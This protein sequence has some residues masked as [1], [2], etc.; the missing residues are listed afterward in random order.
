M[1]N[2]ILSSIAS[3][4]LLTAIAPTSIVALANEEGSERITSSES[5]KFILNEELKNKAD[6]YIQIVNNEF[7]LVDK[8]RD[9]LSDNEIDIVEHFLFEHNQMVSEAMIHNEAPLVQQGNEFIQTAE[10]TSP[11]GMSTMNLSSGG[12]S[13]N[14]TWWGLQIQ[15]SHNAVKELHSYLELGGLI[16]GAA[17]GTIKS[18]LAKKGL[19]IA[20]KWLG[21]VSLAGGVILWGMNKIDNGNGVNLNCI[22]YVPATITAR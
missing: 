21:P 22:L 15:F 9:I 12:V 18:F 4:T 14:Y 13:L 10:D 5:N 7:V 19:T 2:I 6:P 20:A 16:G 8:G 1:K 11:S 17:G 3:V